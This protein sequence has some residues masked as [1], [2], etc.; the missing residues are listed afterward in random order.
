V[1]RLPRD[2]PGPSPAPSD[3]LTSLPFVVIGVAVDDAVP[4]GWLALCDVV[5]EEGSPALEQVASNVDA[6]P[7]ACATLAL[8]LRG[9]TRRSDQDGLV[10]ESASYSVLQAGPEFAAWRARQPARRV[11]DDGV[12]RVRLDRDGGTLQITLSRPDRLNALDAGMRDELAEALTIAAMD[13]SVTRVE[14]RGEGRAFCTG[15]DL[16][17]FG[18]RADPASAHLIRLQRSIGRLLLGLSERTIAY[19][20]GPC[21]GSGIEMAAFAGTVVAGRDTQIALPEIGL[22]LIPGA[23]GTV[24]LPRRIGRL[25][26]SWLAF[27]GCT[28]DAATAQAWGLV[29]EVAT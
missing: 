28:I 2:A 20:H 26:T 7:I 22:G 11:G 13:E 27:S 16:D 21:F 24:S 14:L 4:E 3:R 9:S 1:V 8:L 6:N 17:E 10:G 12:P 19:L 23:G 25:H 29:D 5:V 18:R 15:G